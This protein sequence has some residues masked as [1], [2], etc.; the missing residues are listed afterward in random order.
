MITE[1][2]NEYDVSAP[3]KAAPPVTYKKYVALLTQIGTNN[4][5]AD[6]LE[7]TLGGTLTWTRQ[8]TGIYHATLTNAFP[9]ADKVIC[10]GPGPGTVSNPQTGYDFAKPNANRIELGCLIFDG[11]GLNYSDDGLYK[12]AIEIRV[13]P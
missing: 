9:T 6:V 7:N 1:T 3:G 5:V 11:I 2:D 10:I 8:S 12:S 13:Y 4:P